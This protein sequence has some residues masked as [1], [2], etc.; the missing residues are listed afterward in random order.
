MVHRCDPTGLRPA[1]ARRR[2]LAVVA[3]GQAQGS[4]GEAAG[5]RAG[6]DRHTDED[7]AVVFLHACR[8]GLEGIAK[9]AKR[10]VADAAALAEAKAVIERWNKRLASSRDILWSP[11]IRAAL[12]ARTPWLDMFCPGCGT[13]RV[14]DFR[15]VTVIRLLRSPPWCWGC[16]ARGARNRHRCQRS[17][18]YMRC[19]PRQRPRRR[20]CEP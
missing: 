19:R 1:G 10:Q 2:G 20:T 14:I 11:T 16:G 18:G 9:H 6:W 3:A 7:G 17:S 5:A 8:V 4:P 12:I 15:K 13:S